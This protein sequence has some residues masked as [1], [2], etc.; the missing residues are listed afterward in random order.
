MTK[1]KQNELFIRSSVSSGKL[2]SLSGERRRRS[3]RRRRRRRIS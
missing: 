2:W 3:R 1:V